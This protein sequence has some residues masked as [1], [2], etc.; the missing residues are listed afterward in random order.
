MKYILI[1]IL[2]T[3]LSNN[4]DAQNDFNKNNLTKTFLENAPRGYSF[5]TQKLIEN[6]KII[7]DPSVHYTLKQFPYWE[8]FIA[9]LG[10][11]YSDKQLKKTFKAAYENSPHSICNYYS[12]IFENG[13]NK[14][15]LNLV[16]QSY[17][18]LHREKE[19]Y[20]SICAC[21]FD[22]YDVELIRK[23]QILGKQDQ[24]ER[25]KK[26]FDF[27]LQN[28]IDKKNQRELDKII[29]NIG[30]YPGVSMVGSHVV[31][32][33]W[34]IIQ[35]GDIEYIEKYLEL[36]KKAVREKELPDKY[37][38]YTLDRIDVINGRPQLYGTQ[39]KMVSG[40]EIMYPLLYPNNV[41]KYR[42]QVGLEELLTNK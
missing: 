11:L 41:N 33:A 12:Y 35:H 20:D 29:K 19:Y 7:A 13:F 28:H 18:Y 39:F 15:F 37:L 4:V 36:I 3:S 24:A 10:L 14:Q 30:E 34:L 16:P 40:K 6:K 17:Y 23:L 8:V 21:L 1:I 27:K 26:D 42:K 9:Q 22:K 5:F 32:V 31:D 25:S 2:I 38:A